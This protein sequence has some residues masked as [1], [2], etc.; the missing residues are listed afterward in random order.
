MSGRV[1]LWSDSAA[2]WIYLALGGALT[3][4]YYL[5]VPYPAWRGF[6]YTMIGL[7]ALVAIAWDVAHIK[8][9]SPWTLTMFGLGLALYF[10]GDLTYT[11][12]RF[13][14]HTVPPYPGI[15]DAF[16]LIAR[17]PLFVA[18]LMLARQYDKNRR[19]PFTI[20]DTL[21]VACGLFL[22][23]WTFLLSPLVYNGSLKPGLQ[24]VSLAYPALDF[25][26][27]A[28]G[29]RLIVTSG[30]QTAHHFMVGAAFAA[31][32]LA[33][34]A[35]SG[36]RLTGT[37]HVGTAID[38]GWIWFYLFLGA[39]A[40]FPWQAVPPEPK[41]TINQQLARNRSRETVRLGLLT[42][43][44]EL[45]PIMLAY[46][47]LTRSGHKIDPA[48][49]IIGAVLIF[50]VLLRVFRL[51]R[52]N[53]NLQTELARLKSDV[54]FRSIVE[55]AH[56]GVSQFGPDLSASYHSPNMYQ[57]G[58]IAG[59]DGD[60]RSLVHPDDQARFNKFWLDTLDASKSVPAIEYRLRNPDGEWADVESLSNNLLD[61]EW[62]ARVVLIT[63]DISAR[64]QYE[65]HL[66]KMAFSDYLTD[67]PNRA[68]FDAKLHEMLEQ[69]HARN[70]SIGLVFL[71]L[72]DFGSANDNFGHTVGD[73]VLK[74]LARRIGDQLYEGETLARYGGDEFIIASPNIQTLDD[75]S[76][77][78]QRVSGALNRRFSVRSYDI[79][80]TA[81]VG[82]AV[83]EPNMGADE[84]IRNADLA[85]RQ[86]KS[87]GQGTMRVFTPELLLANRRV[88]ALSTSL[89]SLLGDRDSKAN[90]IGY[91]YMPI[92]SLNDGRNYGLEVIPAWRHPDFGL[93]DND[94][95][96]LVAND[97]NLLYEIEF[98]TMSDVARLLYRWRGLRELSQCRITINLT[99][100]SFAHP[101]FDAILVELL[102]RYGILPSQL[103]LEI[104]EMAILRHQQM[105]IGVLSSVHG[106]GVD[107]I[108]D[109]FAREYSSVLQL[110][111][112]PH[113]AIK[114]DASLIRRLGDEDIATTA[115]GINQVAHELDRI[116][117]ADGVDSAE[118]AR[119]V[120]RLGFD[121]AQGQ[122][123]G[124]P[125]N[126]A[127][128]EQWI[129]SSA[130]VGRTE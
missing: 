70:R 93:I 81:C 37:Y 19:P 20:L 13:V 24:I 107:I 83:S 130:G 120:R 17:I 14:I 46:D 74:Q 28:G 53:A 79:H 122:Y 121:Y 98:R 30:R 6:V 61:D 111:R 55:R 75:A 126:T 117:I 129:K 84:L 73:D 2:W 87:I 91:S 22:L 85:L 44:A 114:Y 40:L 108:I 1:R 39:A 3:A 18:T 67:A 80:L 56:S 92:S 95:L 45:L 25:L 65:R 58:D 78:F 94:E 11:I 38:A 15:A 96:S 125:L 88:H 59:M 106:I 71:D 100:H 54:L 101:Q 102:G 105:A 109:H 33:D 118:L 42:V 89:R 99:D 16:F 10:F 32:L 48:L 21:I 9:R 63:R 50:L 90:R 66:R 113:A 7:S 34:I 68:A 41:L 31:L 115:I 119:H 62:I 49:I 82:I 86:A 43:A 47:W 4:A 123:F 12:Y 64:K 52:S 77:I 127:E 103:A 36:Q 60:F 5:A 8:D 51:M 35:Y 27:L 110:Q 72:D 26:L 76:L 69:A 23:W 104:D 112:L 124:S 29:I 97:S 128:A 116:V 57:I